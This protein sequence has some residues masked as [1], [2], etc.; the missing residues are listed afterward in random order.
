M[1]KEERLLEGLKTR[2]LPPRDTSF[3]P[4]GGKVDDSPTRGA[5]AANQKTLGPRTA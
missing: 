2:Q 3:E 5:T 4:K 1:A